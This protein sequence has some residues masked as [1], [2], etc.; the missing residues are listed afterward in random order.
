MGLLQAYKSPN[1]EQIMEKFR[2]PAKVKGNL[3]SAV[4]VGISDLASTPIG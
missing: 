4:Y 2:D 1:L 3:S